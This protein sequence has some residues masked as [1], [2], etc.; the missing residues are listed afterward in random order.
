MKKLLKK[1]SF[2]LALVITLSIP[3]AAYATTCPNDGNYLTFVGQETYYGIKVAEHQHIVYVYV[4]G[5]IVKTYKPCI[6]KVD[7]YIYHLKCTTC[8]K[9][10]NESGQSAEYHVY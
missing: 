2:L 8:G 6:V 9:I 3:S 7:G 10:I 5:N 4:N 1:I